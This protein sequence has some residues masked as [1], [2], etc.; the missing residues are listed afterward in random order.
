[1]EKT[2]KVI[3]KMLDFKALFHSSV[4]PF[5]FLLM[6]L[7]FLSAISL[8]LSAFKAAPEAYALM[9]IAI[10]LALGFVNSLPNSKGI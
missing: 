3:F 8:V 1:M 9:T 10:P 7:A 2:K 5:L 6:L 4:L